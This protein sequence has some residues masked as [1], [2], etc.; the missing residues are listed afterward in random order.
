MRL[1]ALVFLLPIGV[2]AEIYKCE[3]NGKVSFSDEPCGEAAEVIEVQNVGNT[4][5]RLTTDS[6]EKVSDELYTDRRK[7][8]LDKAIADQYKKIE[9]LADDYDKDLTTLQKQLVELTEGRDYGAWRSHPYKYKD[10]KK[11]KLE[12]KNQIK[13][14]KRK[15]KSDKQ[16]AYDK[17]YQLKSQRRELR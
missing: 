2:Y 7:R 13:Q 15:Y 1:I 14:V 11:R 4:G 16:L 6:M 12:I 9:R 10:Y 3:H 8:E 17:L 5:T